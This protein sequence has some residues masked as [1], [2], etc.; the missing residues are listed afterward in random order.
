MKRSSQHILDEWLVVCSQGGDKQAFERLVQRWQPRLV[1]Y[2]ERQLGD[3]DGAHDVVQDC[4][5]TVAKNLNSLKDATAFP[6]WIYQ[7]LHFKGCD[8]IK[9]R[10]RYRR[11]DRIEV[12][13]ESTQGDS[14]ISRLVQQGLGQ[15][16][17]DHYLTIYFFYIE[18][19]SLHEIAL[20]MD[21]PIGTVKSRLFT[22]RKKLATLIE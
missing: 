20:I 22:A 15:L 19:F 4:L 8:W 3:R 16:E 18:E 12:E 7:I 2:A 10:Q 17:R 1:V 14:S 5:L 9:T 13:P 11:S 21:V 6:K